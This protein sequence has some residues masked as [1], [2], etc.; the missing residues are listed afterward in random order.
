M[1]TLTRITTFVA[2]TPI[3]SAEMNAELNQLVNILNG[4]TSNKNALIKYNDASTPPLQL[5]QLG[6]GAIQQWLQTGV[7]KASIANSGQFVSTV[8]TGT[9]P[10][11]VAST[12]V[13][14]NLNADQVDGFHSTSFARKDDSNPQVFDGN[15][16]V[17][18][19]VPEVILIDENN[20]KHIRF[21]LENTTLFLI[22]ETLTQNIWTV[23]MADNVTT[24]TTIP[25]LPASDPTTAN[26]ATR[27][28]YVDALVAAKTTAFSTGLF[29][30]T[31]PAATES[32]ESVPRFICPEG[33]SITITKLKIV[34]AGGSHTGAT[35]ATWTIK[36]RNAAGVAQADVGTIS[37]NDTNNTV[38]VLYENNIADVPLTAG[39]Q[40]YA[41]LTTRTGTPTETLVTVSFIGTQ[42]LT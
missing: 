36:R 39:D 10:L 22:N 23:N 35:V 24:F 21:A 40:I 25:V 31:I 42:K 28:S 38:D 34:R 15:L 1:A 27:K 5:D 16:V 33:T 19:N 12:T 8:A 18:A 3:L 32:V 37:L 11:S 41:L 2:S 14:A 30:A 17:S 7:V 26:H 4:T 6:A 13:C 9:S 20:S 29:Y